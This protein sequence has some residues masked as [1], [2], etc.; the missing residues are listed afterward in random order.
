MLWQRLKFTP[1]GF[2]CTWKQCA[3]LD[4]D[5]RVPLSKLKHGAAVMAF[6]PHRGDNSGPAARSGWRQETSRHK[7]EKFV[8]VTAYRRTFSHRSLGNAAQL[9]G[10]RC[11]WSTFLVFWSGWSIR[12]WQEQ[13]W[14][15]TEKTWHH[16]MRSKCRTATREISFQAKTI[17]VHF[18]MNQTIPVCVHALTMYTLLCHFSLLLHCSLMVNCKNK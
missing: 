12:V 5:T 16:Y 10:R 18:R 2:G 11:Q 17:W 14:L 7:A 9:E 4:F 15:A 1:A 8:S 13:E 6:V 3:P